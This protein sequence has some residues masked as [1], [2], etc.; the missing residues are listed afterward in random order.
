MQVL[1]NIIDYTWI[2]TLL[3]GSYLGL[4]SMIKK[5]EKIPWLKTYWESLQNS[6]WI[7]IADEVISSVIQLPKLILNLGVK[8]IESKFSLPLLIVAIGFF[9][10]YLNSLLK[11]DNLTKLVFIN[12]LTKGTIVIFI[13]SYFKKSGNKYP[14]DIDFKIL[15]LVLIL[16]MYFPIKIKLILS[17]PEIPFHHAALLAILGMPVIYFMMFFNVFIYI[18][19]Y[20]KI[21]NQNTDK[22]D[23]KVHSFY[24]LNFAIS[25]ALTF[26]AFILG[27]YFEPDLEIPRTMKFFLSNLGFDVLATI[28]LFLSLRWSILEKSTTRIPIALIFVFLVSGLLAILSGYFGVLNTELEMSMSES[29]LMVLGKS[30]N[31]S[32]NNYGPIF[33]AMNTVFIPSIFLIIFITLSYLAKVFL[34]FVMFI[35]KKF[36]IEK[37]LL[38]L[39]AAYIVFLACI[40]RMIKLGIDK[41]VL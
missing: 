16:A 33:W 36:I 13:L 34:I 24:T 3:I 40:L 29:F 12:L 11:V 2:V 1:S 15:L 39:T 41:L 7:S 37:R 18:L 35:L 22:V 10:Y 26:I 17:A 14:Y 28:V 9:D 5:D 20:H 31:G 8:L 4:M 32:T 30:S 25:F 6:E 19:F 21:K 23:L 38:E 27:N